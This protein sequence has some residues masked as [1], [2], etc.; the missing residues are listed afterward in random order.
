MTPAVAVLFALRRE[1]ADFRR[2]VRPRRRIAAPCPVYECVATDG[3]QLLLIETGVGAAAV[4]RALDWLLDVPQRPPF[5]IFAGYAGS[6]CPSLRV[7][8]VF[9]PDAV[10]DTEGRT[11]PTAWPGS[12]R[13]LTTPHLV[14]TPTEKRSLGQRFGARA[15]DMESATFARRCAERGVPFG[16][17]RAISDDVDTVMSS[18]LVGLLAG[19]TVS[20][21]RCAAALARR[22]QLLGEM[23][24]LARS[25]R[26]ASRA[27]AEALTRCAGAPALS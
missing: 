4:D 2:I 15:V 16:C 6:L 26:R 24:R 27:L 1:S 3:R 12:G 25:T 11:W 17:V 20:P 19:G 13:L 22:P 8:D 7:G 5:L 21:W 23:L 10:L 9:I 18:A 14:G